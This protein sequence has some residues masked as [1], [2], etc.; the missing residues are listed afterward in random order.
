MGKS[1]IK[2]V[3]APKSW[4]ISRRTTKWV[5]RSNP[6]PHTLESSMPL[7]VF[8]KEVLNYTKNT[9]ETKF[10]LTNGQVMVNGKIR[11]DQKFPVGIMD[12]LTAGKDNYRIMINKKGQI[13]PI[14]IDEAESKIYLRQVINRTTL[15]GK[16]MQVNLA[17][18]TNLLSNE[19]YNRGDT[20]VFADN[21]IKEHIKLVKG[22]VVYILDGKKVGSY[23]VVKEIK[24][25]KGLQEPKIVLT[26]DKEE[27]ETLQKYAFVIGK[28]KPIITLPNE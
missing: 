5:I 12:V 28:E 26:R 15:K 16:K 7:G 23:G 20:V 9:K 27:F 3:A 22:V 6:G 13:V 10:V 8:I 24:N 18:G 14:K 19:K 11:K 25:N 21:K 17:D 1:H 4:P 2:R